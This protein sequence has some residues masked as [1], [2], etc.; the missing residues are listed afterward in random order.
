MIVDHILGWRRK[1]VRPPTKLLDWTMSPAFAALDWNTWKEKVIPKHTFLCSHLLCR[2]I[3]Y[4]LC[5]DS[6]RGGGIFAWE[7]PELN[8]LCG[9]PNSWG[10]LQF[11]G[12]H[13][14]PTYWLA[15]HDLLMRSLLYALPPCRHQHRTG[16]LRNIKLH[17]CVLNQERM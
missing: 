9:L 14:S 8:P 11:Q 7:D 5:R 12:P 13:P 10:S 16:F 17:I 1:V 2:S 6:R 15:A 3:W 4:L